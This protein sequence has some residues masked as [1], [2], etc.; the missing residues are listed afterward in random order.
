[1]SD[2]L[3][4]EAEEA[5]AG[6]ATLLLARM[7]S[8]DEAAG[9]EL[10]GVLYRELH[11]VAASCMRRES[12]EHTLQ[13]TA[14]V[15]E[16]WVRLVDS[17]STPA[18]EGRGHFVRTA[19]QA[20][21]NV[22]VDHARKKRAQKRGEGARNVPL[23]LVLAGFEERSLDVLELHDALEKLGRVDPELARLVELRFFGGLTVP[24]VASATGRSV[25]TV[26]RQWSVARMWM[27]RELDA[28]D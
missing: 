4:E 11:S 7:T 14:L 5:Q 19:A 9:A 2:E 27:R 8:G 10:L 3:E 12:V 26:E 25:A 17:D 16:A 21:R 20:M 28:G 6:E 13:P 24:E 22:L 23:D 15:H 1:M 18:F